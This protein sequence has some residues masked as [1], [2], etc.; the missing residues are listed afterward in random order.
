MC[1]CMYVMCVM[2]VCMYIYV[3]ILMPKGCQRFHEH[4]NV[5]VCVGGVGVCV[6]E[7]VLRVQG[8][9]VDLV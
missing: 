4:H 8:A 5:C 1:V 6:C 9:S 7:R 2:C 3:P